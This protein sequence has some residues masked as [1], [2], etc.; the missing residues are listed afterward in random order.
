MNN[1]DSMGMKFYATGKAKPSP[2]GAAGET[3]VGAD[4]TPRGVSTSIGGGASSSAMRGGIGQDDTYF[5]IKRAKAM[6]A[7][8]A[9]LYKQLGGIAEQ[10]IPDGNV[11]DTSYGV[12]VG[13]VMGSMELDPPQTRINKD[14]VSVWA[15][16]VR[17]SGVFSLERE[18]EWTGRPVAQ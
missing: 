2:V 13:G 8:S 3:A 18:G 15:E 11:L 12:R 7:G 6:S 17:T 5:M 10:R 14:A 4:S 16:Q 9:P 1:R